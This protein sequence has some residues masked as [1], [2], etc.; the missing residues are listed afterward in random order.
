MRPVYIRA[1]RDQILSAEQFPYLLRSQFLTSDICRSLHDL[2]EFNLQPARHH[3]LII[4]LQEVRD[5][6]L[7]RLT[8]DPNDRVVG[9][10]QMSTSVLAARPFLMASWCDPEKAVKTKS[11]T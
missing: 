4:A 10:S 11:P 2:A 3:Q 5:P 1:A 6:A 7:S 8:I 9:T